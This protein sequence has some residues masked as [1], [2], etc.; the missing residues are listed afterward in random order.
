MIAVM[1]TFTAFYSLLKVP[2]S[3]Q[4]VSLGEGLEF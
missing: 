4:K 1:K 3:V 2:I